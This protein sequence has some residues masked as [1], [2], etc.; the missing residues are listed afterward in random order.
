MQAPLPSAVSGQSEAGTDGGKHQAKAPKT[1]A[2]GREP[3]EASR[4]TCLDGW[5][6]LAS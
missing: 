2:I 1:L 4:G 3:F 6:W 5:A